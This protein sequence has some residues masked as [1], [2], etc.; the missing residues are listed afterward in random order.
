MQPEILGQLKYPVTS[1]GTEATTF[2]LA[3][4]HLNTFQYENHK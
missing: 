1:L 2:G 4:K 3:A